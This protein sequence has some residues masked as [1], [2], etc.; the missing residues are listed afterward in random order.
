VQGPL[1]LSNHQLF[2]FYQ[3]FNNLVRYW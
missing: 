2:E 3:I 1:Q